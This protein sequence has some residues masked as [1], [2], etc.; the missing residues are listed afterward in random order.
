[1][2]DLMFF[3]KTLA[4]TIV[5]VAFLQIRVEGKS[6][7]HHT[8]QWVQTSAVVEPLND[9]AQG[10]AK[11]VHDVTQTA[12]SRIHKKISRSHA[13]PSHSSEYSSSEPDGE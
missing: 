9:V 8:M 1:M 4:L 10:A 7:E 6:I 12:Y 11:L 2:I 5:M 3:L 13:K